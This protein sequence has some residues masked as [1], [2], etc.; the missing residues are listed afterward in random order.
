MYRHCIAQSLHVACCKAALTSCWC[1]SG[2]P[3]PLALNLQVWAHPDDLATIIQGIRAQEQLSGP[4][5]VSWRVCGRYSPQN[6]Q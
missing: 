2:P 3:K 6:Y 1:C 4:R 5:L